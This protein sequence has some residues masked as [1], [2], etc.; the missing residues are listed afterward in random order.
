MSSVCSRA[1]IAKPGSASR[2][3]PLFGGSTRIRPNGST[4]AVDAAHVRWDET[5]RGRRPQTPSVL[6][7]AEAV[8][9]SEPL[10][11]YLIRP[12]RRLRVTSPPWVAVT[13]PTP[14][15]NSARQFGQRLDAERR[16]IGERFL[17][18]SVDI[19]AAYFEVSGCEPTAADVPPGAGRF[20]TLRNWLY[21]R[22]V[23]DGDWLTASR[24][25]AGNPLDIATD[26]SRPR[27]T[28]TG[29][30]V[31]RLQGRLQ[32]GELRLSHRAVGL[33]Q[34]TVPWPLQRS[35][36]IES[37]R[38]VGTP[39]QSLP[40]WPRR[41]LPA[42][43]HGRAVRE[44][45]TPAAGALVVLPVEE[46][47][48]LVA[49]AAADGRFTM[50]FSPPLARAW[51]EHEVQRGLSDEARRSVP[52]LAFDRDTPLTAWHT[53]DALDLPEYELLRPTLIDASPWRLVP[54]WNETL[55]AP[56]SFR[57]QPPLV[58]TAWSPQPPP[59]EVGLGTEGWGRLHG[60]WTILSLR[61]PLDD[62]TA[63]LL[64]EFAVYQRTA[65]GVL[66]R[67]RERLVASTL[68]HANAVAARTG[69]PAWQRV[70]VRP[71][72]RGDDLAGEVRPHQYDVRVLSRRVSNSWQS[73]LADG[74]VLVDPHGRIAW[75]NTPD[76]PPLDANLPAIVHAIAS[77]G[78]SR[79]DELPPPRRVQPDD[80]TE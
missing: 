30:S 67:L 21:Q 29:R 70:V 66:H 34:L 51:L 16:S 17:A 24:F 39:T 11:Q 46:S 14:P 80:A 42:C 60:R 33:S 25:R 20:V 6:V 79:G 54:G 38:E 71:L 52:L 74:D 37:P 10:M 2:H 1:S 57:G 31:D 19:P 36:V 64:R 9:L 61:P 56:N 58:P 49:R 4:H 7:Q 15:T 40:A 48:D 53:F 43:L 26:A 32:T 18:E 77:L 23:E 75:A 62:N 55:P 69:G 68:A 63:E 3:E 73:L 45:G 5:Q 13:M 50:P 65:D 44:D 12:G 28:S 59:T 47:V 8:D 22:P 41:G 78:L 27:F 72:V 35:L 76:R